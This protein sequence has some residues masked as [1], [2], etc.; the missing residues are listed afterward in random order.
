MKYLYLFLA[1][2]SSTIFF[3]ACSKDSS[4]DARVDAAGGGATGAGG[5]LARFAIVN[6]YMYTIDDN[7]LRVFNITVP[8]NPQLVRIVP[9]GFSIETIY[10]FKGKL[11]IGST[12]AVFIFSIDVPD[13][14]VKLGEA[15]SPQVLRRCDPVVAKDTVAY[16]TLRTNGPCGGLQSI[17]AVYDIKDPTKPFQ[18][19]SIPLTEPYGIGYSDSA[20]YVCDRGRGLVI[21]NISSPFNPVFTSSKN[22]GE[23]V[24]VIPYLGTLICWVKGGI[25]LYDISQPLTPV[26]LSKIN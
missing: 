21:Y 26:F 13:Q 15:I 22:D 11:F 14:P 23:Y 25:I 6:N 24:D 2:F 9:V 4:G 1:L 7:N 3:Q 12:S 18:K 5:S 20:L 17:L 8:D 16:A 10:P 19:N